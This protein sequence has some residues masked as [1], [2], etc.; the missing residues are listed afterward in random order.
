MLLDRLQ[1]VV[2]QLLAQHREEAH[3]SLGLKAIGVLVGDRAQLFERAQVQVQ[4]PYRP[5]EDV[6][7]S[8]TAPQSPDLPFAG[9]GFDGERVQLPDERRVRETVGE[10]PLAVDDRI[11][12]DEAGQQP[13]LRH[14]IQELVAI[15]HHGP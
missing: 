14:L 11:G 13:A 10:H 7:G 4:Q 2:G 15:R 3:E 1:I 9:E 5:V 6:R 12:I 8:G